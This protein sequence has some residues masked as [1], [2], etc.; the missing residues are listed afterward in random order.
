MSREALDCNEFVELVTDYLDGAMD[1]ETQARF[2]SHMVDCDGCCN[3]LE[4]FRVTVRTLGALHAD[5]L[6]AGFRNR[7]LDALSGWNNT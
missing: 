1:R 3:Y 2:D 6:E 4:R 7:L 5:E